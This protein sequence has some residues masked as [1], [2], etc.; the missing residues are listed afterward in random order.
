MA[1]ID[2]DVSD[3][4]QAELTALLNAEWDRRLGVGDQH[5]WDASQDWL[6]GWCKEHECSQSICDSIGWHD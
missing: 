2:V 3:D 1:V 4:V 6:R 5:V